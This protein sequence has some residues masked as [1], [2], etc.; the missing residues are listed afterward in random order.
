MIAVHVMARCRV[1]QGVDPHRAKY[2]IL[3]GRR[4]G[5][6]VRRDPVIARSDAPG[7]GVLHTRQLVIRDI[8]RP[9]AIFGAQRHQARRRIANRPV[10][11]DI[12]HVLHRCRVAATGL[13]ELGP[14][15][16][17]HDP[18]GGVGHVV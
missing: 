7:H 11:M 2:R 5:I 4:I 10:D 3:T 18:V 13:D 15:A 14:A 6:I 16:R 9:A 8:A 1:Q 12:M 17:L